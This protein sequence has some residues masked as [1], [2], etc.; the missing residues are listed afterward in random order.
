MLA[1][2][3]A[4]M[5]DADIGYF[6]MKNTRLTLVS[7]L[8]SVYVANTPAGR[9]CADMIRNY[10]LAKLP[11]A[12][13]WLLDQ[14]AVYCVTQFL[15]AQ[16]S[17]LRLQDFSANPGGAFADYVDVASSAGE[18]QDMRKQAGSAIAA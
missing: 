8:A 5:R 16:P 14:A 12:S 6:Q 3:V 13:L 18:K 7:H 2:L 15:A 4:A 1:A 9:R 10:V 11:D 17:G